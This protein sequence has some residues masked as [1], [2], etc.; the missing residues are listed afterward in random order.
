[1]AAKSKSWPSIILKILAVLILLVVS[2]SL[3]SNNMR[4]WL[5]LDDAARIAEEEDINPEWVMAIMMVESKFNPNEI[6]RVGAIGLMQLMPATAK[7]VAQELKMDTQCLDLFDPITNIK[8][9]CH[10]LANLKKRYPEGTIIVFAAYHAGE[11]A[12]DRWLAD[13]NPSDFKVEQ[14]PVP[15][16]MLYA[17]AV[18]NSLMLFRLYWK[19][20]TFFY[21]LKA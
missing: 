9:G 15:E 4:Q 13:G 2:C 20:S 8:L 12:A 6:S 10:Y 16:T 11:G 21:P 3:I 17:K 7:R 19:M 18:N 1:M 5:Y 14:I